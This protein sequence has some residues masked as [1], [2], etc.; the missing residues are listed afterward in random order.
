MVMSEYASFPVR[1]AA[2]RGRNSGTRRYT[3]GSAP[4]EA[5][6][7]HDQLAR[8]TR[9]VG[10]ASYE[11]FSAY[12]WRLIVDGHSG[13]YPGLYSEMMSVLG[14]LPAGDSVGLLRALGVDLI[15]VHED[16]Y[17]P[18]AY[19]ALQSRM[20]ENPE[21]AALQRLGRDHVY[22]VRHRT[23]DGQ[24]GG[25]G[26][27]AELSSSTRMLLSPTQNSPGQFPCRCRVSTCLFEKN[28]PI[29]LLIPLQE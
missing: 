2:H 10:D 6:H 17:R 14:H 7:G 15:I 22:R 23:G 11:Y 20:A 9:S 4:P 1:I 8:G 25:L 21:L 29:L 13:F 28:P 3:A 26:T 5:P 16:G 27:E 19:R 24:T 12:H 18:D